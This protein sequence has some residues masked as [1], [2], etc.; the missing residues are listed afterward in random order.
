MSDDVAWNSSAD[1]VYG[2]LID[3]GVTIIQT[4]RPEFL[5][6]YLREKGLHDYRDD[7]L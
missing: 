1:E 3:I 7:D 6:N 2:N 4:D 5:L